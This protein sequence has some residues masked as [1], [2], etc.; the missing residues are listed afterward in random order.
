MA[1]GPVLGH[2]DQEAKHLRSTKIIPSDSPLEPSDPD[3]KPEL[4]LPSHH[5]FSML[6]EKS[7]VMKSYSDRTG[8]FPV[9]SSRGKNYI[10]VLYHYDTNTIHAVAI[11]NRQ[12][13]S[14]RN[15]WETVHKKLIQQGHAPN[16]HILDNKCSQELKDYFA[17]YK[18]AFQRVP[19]KEHRANAAKRAIRTF[20]NHLISTLCSVDSNFPMT[21]WDRLLPQKHLTLNLL[22]SSRIHPSLLA[23]AS[24]FGNFAFNRTPIALPG[25][26]IVAHTSAYTQTTFGEHGQVGWYIGP[27]PE[28]YRC[29]KCYFPST[30]SER[31]VLTVDFFTLKNSFSQTYLRQLSQ[32]NRWRYAAPPSNSSFFIFTNA[33]SSLRL[34]HSKCLFKSC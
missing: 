8:R 19:P 29:Y 7:Q 13:A 20:K 11:P 14:I 31:D 33:G 24:L 32:T 22:P 9:P 16:L 2:Q 21:E 10:F 1:Y 34:S 4:A 12:A 23:H 6:F 26:K 27:S 15:A 30:M 25:T 17:K 18:I 28:H 3:L 5:I